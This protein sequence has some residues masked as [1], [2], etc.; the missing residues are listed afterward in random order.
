MSTRGDDV[1]NSLK[2]LAIFTTMRANLAFVDSF[3][4]M[5]FLEAPCN[6]NLPDLGFLGLERG[7]EQRRAHNSAVLTL[8]AS[9]LYQAFKNY[10]DLKRFKPGL[11][12]PDV[13]NFLDG[14][15][16]RQ[17]FIEGLRVIR[18]HTFHICGLA[19]KESE[20][21][22]VF[23]QVCEQ[24]GGPQSVLQQ[25]LTHLHE[26]AEKC[27]MGE[28]RIHPEQQYEDLERHKSEDPLFAAR[29]EKGELTLEDLSRVLSRDFVVDMR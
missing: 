7:D 8:V 11:E 1:S 12:D 4:R 27:F 10:C 3:M 21:L 16:D 15:R 24:V 26:F 22:T 9:L 2:A 19:R 20:S 17:Q 25:L 13:E 14:L 29:W 28:L 23:G 6:P 5:S 18:N